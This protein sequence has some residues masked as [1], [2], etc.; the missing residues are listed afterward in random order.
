MIGTSPDGRGGCSWSRD[1]PGQS[2]GVGRRIRY[3]SPDSVPVSYLAAAVC[4]ILKRRDERFD[5]EDQL[6]S[7]LDEDKVDWNPDDLATAL[8][9]L[10][11]IG[12]LRRPRADQWRS[13]STLAA[14]YVSPRIFQE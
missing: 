4:A 1:A 13:G 7:W 9:H 2:S 10:E 11:R 3:G 8:D 14:I 12:G 6:Q 5:S